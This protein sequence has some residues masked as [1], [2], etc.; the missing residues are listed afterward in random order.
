M[1]TWV[2]ILGFSVHPPNNLA[3]CASLLEQSGQL[4]FLLQKGFSTGFSSSFYDKVR[5]FYVPL[6]RRVMR[7]FTR[8]RPTSCIGFLE[9]SAER[10]AP[11]LGNPFDLLF[12]AKCLSCF[13]FIEIN[14]SLVTLNNCLIGLN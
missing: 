6:P 13:Q 4:D 12:N 2:T 1:V 14:S 8:P 9:R 5:H 11:D 3:V 7:F 10:E